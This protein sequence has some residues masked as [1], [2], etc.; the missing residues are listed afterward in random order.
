MIQLTQESIDFIKSISRERYPNEAVFGVISE[1]EVIELTNTHEKPQEQFK[2]NSD[3]FYGAGCIALV[4]SHTVK[5]GDMGHS[6]MYI[7]PR[8]PSEAD[9]QTQ[10]QMDIPFGILALD[11]ETTL[12]IVWFPDLDSEILGQEYI[13][14]IHDCYTLIQKY[15]WQKKGIK[16]KT[17][18]HSA[19]WFENN[20]RLY[21][22]NYRYGGF[23][24]SSLENIKIG[25]M[26]LIRLFHDSPTHAA[27]YV[28]NDTIWHHTANRLSHE[29]SLSKWVKRISKVL[30][31]KGE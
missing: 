30:T 7:D 13:S 5:R 10:M 2:V 15:Y 31:Y 6:E 3:S 22:E 21:E 8:T 25:D 18:A 26:V 9:M 27:V 14:G 4:H 16:L 23:E 28:G 19:T 29:D 12:D 20:P 1:D 17:V 24:D 11:E